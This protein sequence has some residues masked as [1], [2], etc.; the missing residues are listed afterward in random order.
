MTVCYKGEAPQEVG[1]EEQTSGGDT[2]QKETV[3]SQYANGSFEHVQLR[4][5]YLLIVYY[6]TGTAVSLFAWVRNTLLYPGLFSARA[7]IF[8]FCLPFIK[9][10]FSHTIYP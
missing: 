9:N 2:P 4:L 1:R 5:T 7:T 10:I 3:L 8:L 6:D